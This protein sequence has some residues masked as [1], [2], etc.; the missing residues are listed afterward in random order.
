MLAGRQRISAFAQE[1]VKKVEPQTVGNYIS[2]LS[3][4]VAVP[5]RCG[6]TRSTGRR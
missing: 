4:V 1:L 5:S 3:A 6:N 2:H